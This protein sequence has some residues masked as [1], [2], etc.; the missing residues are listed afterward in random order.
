MKDI[1]PGHGPTLWVVENYV[2]YYS[3]GGTVSLR[4]HA[5]EI[6]DLPV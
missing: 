6:S 1:A 4:V 5:H 2:S 3:I